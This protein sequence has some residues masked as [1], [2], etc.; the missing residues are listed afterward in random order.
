MVTEY[1]MALY[2]R[3]N[4]L[5]LMCENKTEHFFDWNNMKVRPCTAELG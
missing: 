4:S 3:N 5:T 2:L 1:C